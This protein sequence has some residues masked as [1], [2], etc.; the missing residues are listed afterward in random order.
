MNS[1]YIYLH[2]FASGPSSRKAQYFKHQFQDIGQNLAIPDLNQG[3]FQTLTLTRQLQQLEHIAEDNSVILIGSSLGGLTATWFAQT[4][5]QV[6]RLVLLAPAFQFLAHWLP[7]FSAAQL[8]H[9]KAGGTVKIFHHA[10]KRELP[11]NYAFVED[12]R[13][14]N[15]QSLQRDIPTLIMHGVNDRTIPIAASYQYARVRRWVK[16]MPMQSDHALGNVLPEMW[17]SLADFL[18]L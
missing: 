3:N 15:E 2:G 9:W 17:R 5:L 12:L 14:Y 10:A 6:K 16:V 7:H 11:L 8:D 18:A 1:S 13:D 4:H